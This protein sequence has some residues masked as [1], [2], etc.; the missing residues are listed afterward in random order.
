MVEARRIRVLNLIPDSRLGGPHMRVCTLGRA[1]LRHGVETLVA[2]GPGSAAEHAM[3]V[4]LPWVP[5]VFRRFRIRHIV[6]N[7]L[8]AMASLPADQARLAAVLARERIDILQCNSIM[9]IVGPPAG[10]R[11]GVKVLW[12]LNDMIVPGI[13]CRGTLA[14][15]GRLADRVVFASRAVKE[16]VGRGRSGT[17]DIMYPPV[18]TARFG[19]AELREQARAVRERHGLDPELPTVITVANVCNGKGMD[20]LVEAMGLLAGEGAKVQLLIVGAVAQPDA[21]ASLLRQ[22]ERRGVANRVAFAG[23]RSDV[24]TY[25]ASS[26]VFAL[27]SD[28]E[29]MSVALF[30]GMA[31]GLPCVA[32]RVGGAAEVIDDGV[33]GLLVPP[34]TPGELARALARL[35]R[36]RALCEALGHRARQVMCRSFDVQVVAE[37]QV[38]IYHDMLREG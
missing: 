18:D 33:S 29:A 1:M 23:Y 26:D 5:F 4:G 8:R 32:T 16:H 2:V 38:G 9:T 21:H 24:E 3:K 19:R 7:A 28:S 20:H 36:D 12:H 11:A 34:R 30:E 17:D 25:L 10:R 37:R 14:T 22:A 15:V 31:S 6:M 27:A 35:L 13:V